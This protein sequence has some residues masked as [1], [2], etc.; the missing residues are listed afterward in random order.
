MAETITEARRREASAIRLS[1]DRLALILWLGFV[2]V[3]LLLHRDAIAALSFSDPDNAMRLVQVRDL[4]GGQSW[5]DTTQ[6]RTNP[7]GGGGPTHWSR[8]VDAPIAALI[9]LLS[10]FFEPQA[11][12]RW[13]L[14]LYPPFLALP[15]LLVFSRILQILGGRQF[16]FIG[17]A[18]AAT[19][20]S[21]LHHF[22]PLNIDHH[23]WQVLLSVVLLWLALRPASFAN[24]F[25]SAFVAAI[26]VEISLEGFPLLGL[27]WALFVVD[28]LRDPAKANRLRGF[29]AGM[30]LLPALWALP[31]RG[32][33][34]VVSI[35]CDSFSLPYIVATALAGLVFTAFL[36][37]PFRWTATL[38]RRITPVIIAGLLFGAGFVLTGP[39][40]LSGP[41]GTLE[42][43]VRTYWYDPILEGRP[44]WAQ[45]PARLLAYI[46]PSLVGLLAT[47]GACWKARGRPDAENWFR[48]AFLILCSAILAMLVIR[49]LNVAHAFMV[50]A[51]AALATGLWRWIH[52]QS[53]MARRLCGHLL[54]LLS[55]PTV[56]IALGYRLSSLVAGPA[57]LPEARPQNAA[58]LQSNPAL[59]GEPPTLLFTSTHIAPA[60]L[61]STPHSVVATGHHRN[62]AALNRVISAFLAPPDVARSLVRAEGARYVV[63]CSGELG[64]LA[65]ANRNGLA[66]H[67]IQGRAVD[68]LEP[69]HRFSSGGLQVYRVVYP[70]AKKRGISEKPI[71]ALTSF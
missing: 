23:G 16:T 47:I 31:F 10:L 17:L 40:C 26:Y 62:H 57:K 11:A 37:A 69:Q 32:T 71:P 20:L 9:A 61:V 58:C 52:A 28:W 6:Y 33:T 59:A 24:G 4:G 27:F 18:I 63:F 14:A 35:L 41:F 15:L 30:I 54:L 43:L 60:L 48:L 55:I 39:S 13:V 12:E 5:F 50:P 66:A 67:L 42:P 38:P 25:L 49:A 2:A 1:P 29:S 68:W 8:F 46:L 65:A 22:A 45:E 36:A 3:S 64:P 21:Y 51:F 19:T 70:A 44:L 56:D 34:Y 7:M 53:N